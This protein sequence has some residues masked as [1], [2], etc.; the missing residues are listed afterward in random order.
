VRDGEKWNHLRATM[1]GLL[2]K[3]SWLRGANLDG[4]L[5]HKAIYVD[6]NLPGWF[7]LTVKKILKMLF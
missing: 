6:I 1:Q 7:P 5:G 4:A 2:K 3:S